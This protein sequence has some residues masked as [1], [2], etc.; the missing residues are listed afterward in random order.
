MAIPKSTKIASAVLLTVAV[1]ASIYCLNRP[2][3]SGSTQ[4]TDFAYVQADI[5]QVASR[6]SGTITSVLVKDNQPVKAGDLLLTLD[7]RDFI[8]AKQAA[9]AD[10]ASAQAHIQDIHAQLALQEA[11][12]QQAQASVAASEAAIKLATANNTRYRNLAKDGSGTV[13]AQ[14]EAQTQS[15]T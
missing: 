4:S 1:I 14:Q 6:V 13:Q 7:D 5:T 12:I 3:S 2:E 9:Q 11:V 15:C 10:V 8:V